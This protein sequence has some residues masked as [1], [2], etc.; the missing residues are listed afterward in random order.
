MM[1][2]FVMLSEKLR[3]GDGGQVFF[4]CPGCKVPHGI[5]VGAGAGPR[6]QW[7]GNVDRPTF[8][9]SI[10]VRYPWGSPQ[11]EKICHS[12]VTDGRIQFLSDCTHILA[13]QTVDIPDWNTV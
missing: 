13:G 10:L 1:G 11:V 2:E 5:N 12:Y 8:S 4:E 9:P 7:N 3:G 6:W